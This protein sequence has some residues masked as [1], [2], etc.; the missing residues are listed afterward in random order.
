MHHVIYPHVESRPLT[1]H[2]LIFQNGDIFSKDASSAKKSWF[3][4]QL[5]RPNHLIT[6]RDYVLYNTIIVYTL[7]C[8]LIVTITYLPSRTFFSYNIYQG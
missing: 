1:V 3:E 2:G 8:K 7:L 6:R 4:F 5:N